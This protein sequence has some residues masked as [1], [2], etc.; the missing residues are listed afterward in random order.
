VLLQEGPDSAYD[1]A[2]IKLS[3]GGSDAKVAR[4][5]CLLSNTFIDP[6]GPEQGFAITNPAKTNIGYRS[7]N[8][9][10]VG[11]DFGGD[12]STLT[13]SGYPRVVKSWKRGTPLE[14]AVTV[15]EGEQTDILAYQSSY[16]DRGFAH[17]FQVR[18]ITFYSSKH[19]YRP[20][21][22]ES[23]K[24]TTADAEATPFKEV[25]M[26]ADAEIGTFA[27]MALLTLRSDMEQGDH[28]SFAAGSLVTLPLEELMENNWSNATALFT[29]TPSRSLSHNTECKDYI[30]LKILED[31]KT[32]LEFHKYDP[33]TKA[34]VQ[35][36]GGDGAAVPVGEDVGVGSHCRDSSFDNT[37]WLMRDG[38]L[39]PD[40]LEMASAEDCCSSPKPVKAKPA[41]FNA[42]G[43]T[44][45]QNFAT[46][47][48]GTKIPYFVIRREDL[49]MDRTNP[50][51]LDAYGGFEIS[52][53]PGYSAGVGAGWLE[54]GGIKVIA[55]IRGGGEYGPK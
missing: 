11:T 8:E 42:D 39:I 44:V 22:P 21:T 1:R 12:G 40:A 54:R 23:M 13:D 50:V 36:S 15:F 53:L 7:R 9:V 27:N 43:L 28:K 55:N 51:L 24:E 19:W 5:F 26:P 41:M 14:E 31:V 10:L 4:E 46:S 2:I 17:E 45:L 3:P 20:L 35:Q 32:V 6:D 48:D 47:L 37:L 33:D 30:I 18:Q 16:L 25:P 52:M 29:P 34:F 49:K 38:Y